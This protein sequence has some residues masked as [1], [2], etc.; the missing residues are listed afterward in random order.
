MFDHNTMYDTIRFNLDVVGTPISIYNYYCM[1]LLFHEHTI[2]V[3]LGRASK[4]S[5]A[6]HHIDREVENVLT[7]HTRCSIL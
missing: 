6:V 2:G 7:T 5:V 1:L 3:N 4:L